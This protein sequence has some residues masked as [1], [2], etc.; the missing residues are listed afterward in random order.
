MNIRSLWLP[1]AL[2]GA[3]KQELQSVRCASLGLGTVSTPPTNAQGSSRPGILI[4]LQWKEI[5]MREIKEAWA[6]R[7]QTGKGIDL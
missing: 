6:L 3:Q 4:S 2:K 1:Q 7:L 5:Y